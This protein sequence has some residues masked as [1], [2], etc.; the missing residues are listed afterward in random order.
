[1]IICGGK[2]MLGHGG[3]FL[4]IW[5]VAVPTSFIAFFFIESL[6]LQFNS[7]WHCIFFSRAQRCIYWLKSII[8]RR[9]SCMIIGFKKKLSPRIERWLR[10]NIAPTQ[11]KNREWNQSIFWYL[12][13]VKYSSFHVGLIKFTINSENMRISFQEE[14]RFKPGGWH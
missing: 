2:T 1:M 12:Y 13:Y 14:I 3:L 9:D 10:L 4:H 5:L 7:I 6:L 8:V 11:K